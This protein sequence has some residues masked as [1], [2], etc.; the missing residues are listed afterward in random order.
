MLTA[1]VII[2]SYNHVESIERAIDSVLD[3]TFQDY[4]IIIVDDGSTDGSVE[5]IK[6]YEHLNKNIKA[7]YENHSGLMNS[8]LKGFSKNLSPSPKLL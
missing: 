1:N 8:Y 6:K 5:I 2:V 7:Y 3:Q 4:R